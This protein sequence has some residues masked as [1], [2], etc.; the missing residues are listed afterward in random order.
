M[1]LQL[2]N[3]LCM[4]AFKCLKGS[5]CASHRFPFHKF[6]RSCFFY[7]LIFI[8]FLSSPGFFFHFFSSFYYSS[9]IQFLLHVFSFFCCF[10]VYFFYFFFTSRPSQVSCLHLTRMEHTVYSVCARVFIYFRSVRKCTDTRVGGIP[11]IF[12]IFNLAV[13]KQVPQR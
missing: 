10:V 2:R 9:R 5:E 4:R 12:G 6:V 8:L 13:C 1:R 3:M 11:N 7:G